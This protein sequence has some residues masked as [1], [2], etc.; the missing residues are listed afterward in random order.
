MPKAKPDPDDEQLDE[1][2]R[3]ADDGEVLHRD[4]RPV[5]VDRPRQPQATFA[6]RLPPEDVAEIRR[7]IGK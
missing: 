1:R 2:R 5:E 3:E 7:L 6:L 4:L